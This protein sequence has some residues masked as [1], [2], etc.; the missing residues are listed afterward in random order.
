MAAIERLDCRTG[1]YIA[2]YRIESVLGEGSFGTVFR[3]KDANGR[4]YA[5]K[6][7]KLWA[8]PPNIRQ[9]LLARF[10]MEFETGQIRS[11]Y[12]VHSIEHGFHRDVPYI[13]MEYCAGGNL[14]KLMGKTENA[15]MTQIARDILCG[16][17]DLHR[18]GKVHRDLKPENVLFKTD[19]TA[20]LTDFGIAGD[21]NKRLTEMRTWG[22]PG[23]IFGTYG[24]MPPEQVA[25]DREATVLPT[26][27]I[28]SFGVVMYLT[29]TGRLPF[30]NLGNDSD[31]V[32]YIR[33][34]R[35]GIWD[36]S[37]LQRAPCGQTFLPL[38]S[39]C[40]KPNFRQR[41]QTAD[42]AL[43][44]LPAVSFAN[45]KKTIDAGDFQREIRKGLL[46]RVMQ[47][48]EYGK[49]YKLNDLLRGQGRVLTVGRFDGGDT[50]NSLQIVEN[51]SRY[52]SRRH[53]TLELD[54]AS[55][56]WFIRDGQW[57]KNA[58][59][60]WRRSLNGTFVNSVEAPKNGISIAVG[61]II[62]VG[63]VKLRVEGY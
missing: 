33:R 14:L 51:Q 52:I 49:T 54:F 4:E 61:D 8:I 36:S 16:L 43:A 34:G 39:A 18:S 23:Q 46:L 19:G 28:F 30:G 56:S 9:S 27:D 48:E 60:G 5:L 21:R 53:C 29:L 24:F 41:L 37:A 20:A 55:H 11:D 58:D 17:R 13:V 42:E 26:T 2:G 3:V 45:Q 15:D 12:L 6:L 7:L 44:M 50:A 38:I 40:L 47:G 35:E 59:D 10:D 62:S 32:E 57:D 63:D 25:A 31:L 22:S 1:D